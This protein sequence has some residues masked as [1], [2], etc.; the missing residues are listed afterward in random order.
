MKHGKADEGNE[1]CNRK[2]GREETT[3][4][5]NINMHHKYDKNVRI[6]DFLKMVMNLQVP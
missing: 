2:I 6:T 5:T 4:E 1:H 3:R